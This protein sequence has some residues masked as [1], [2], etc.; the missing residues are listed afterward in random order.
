[1]REHVY[2]HKTVQRPCRKRTYVAYI[3]YSYGCNTAETLRRRKDEAR[4]QRKLGV[5]KVT[6]GKR[7]LF[8]RLEPPG[9]LADPL[10]ASQQ[11]LAIS[12][13]SSFLAIPD[14]DLV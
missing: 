8:H 5:V 14:C 10:S 12:T 3:S 2:R 11:L 4:R 9:C 6:A 7:S 13:A 1:M